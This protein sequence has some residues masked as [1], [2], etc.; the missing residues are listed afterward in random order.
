MTANRFSPLVKSRSSPERFMF[1][2]RCVSLSS[3][4]ELGD[5]RHLSNAFVWYA[6]LSCAV[7]RSGPAEIWNADVGKAKPLVGDQIRSEDTRTASPAHCSLPP[8]M[9]RT[10]INVSAVE[11]VN[12]EPR[13][14][15][16]IGWENEDIN[17]R[18]RSVIDRPR[19]WRVV[20][21]LL[22]SVLRLHHLGASV[23]ARRGRKPDR[24]YRQCN[25]NQFR[26][27]DRYPPV[28]LD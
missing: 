23:R 6:A 22:R 12:A 10:P 2:I 26:P 8:V 27:H 24:R 11:S 3:A 21:R 7:C 1:A 13:P 17:R 14:V 25:H 28:V 19:W 4:R 15:I 16:A 5:G 20:V 9:I 18:R